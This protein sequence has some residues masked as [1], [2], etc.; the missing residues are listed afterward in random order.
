MAIDYTLEN[1]DEL[2][3]SLKSLYVEKDGKYVLDVKGVDDY[4]QRITAMDKKISELLTEKKT[5]AEKR[6]E[7]EGRAEKERLELAKKSGDI[8]SLESSWSQKHEKALASLKGEYDETK[9]KLESLLY[10]ST[11]DAQAL[12]IASELAVPGSARALLPHIKSRLSMNINGDSINAAVLSQDGKPSALT[13]DELKAEIR[14]DEAL[15]PLIVG[16][17]ASGGGAASSN[18][19]AEAKTITRSQFDTMSHAERQAHFQSGGEIK[20]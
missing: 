6:K 1:I 16:S 17:K 4:E 3:E 7:A 20:N 9:T 10:K 5:E 12:Q 13:L 8:E 19:G 2:D 14:N 11:V 15:A 18:G